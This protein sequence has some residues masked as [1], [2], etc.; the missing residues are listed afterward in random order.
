[1]STIRTITDHPTEIDLLLSD[2]V[3]PEMNGRDLAARLLALRPGLRCLFMSGLTPEVL[4]GDQ[5]PAERFRFLQKPLSIADLALGV[6]Q[7]LDAPPH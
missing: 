2:V 4:A 3:M 5:A 6:R 1:M 7:A